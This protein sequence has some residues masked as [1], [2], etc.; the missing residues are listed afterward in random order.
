MAIGFKM[1]GITPFV[2]VPNGK[3]VLPVN[4]IDLLLRC[5]GIKGSTITTLSELLADT[6]T[7]QA[8]INSNN[9]IDYLVRSTEFA[10]SEALVPTMTSDTEPSGVASASSVYNSSYPAWKVFD[11][12]LNVS[13]S[14][15]SNGTTNQWVKYR[16]P[17]AQCVKSVS[18]YTNFTGGADS[19]IKNFRVEGSNDDS[20]F[21]TI[22]TGTYLNQSGNQSFSFSNNESY[23]YYRLYI[24]DRYSASTTNIQFVELQYYDSA[25]GF[26]ENSTAMTYIGAN[27]YASDTLLDDSTWLNA[28]CNSTYFESVLNVKVPTM[29]SNTTPSGEVITSSNIS[30]FD[31][32]KAFDENT[33]SSW[34]VNSASLNGSYIIYH[35]TSQVRVNKV[36]NNYR[37]DRGSVVKYTVWELYGSNDNVSYTD[38]GEINAN[39]DGVNTTNILANSNKYSYY[40]LV[41]KSASASGT[42]YGFAILQFYGRQDV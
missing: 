37:T 21:T 7:L 28:I 24:I 42:N 20:E 35:F 33:S 22:Y 36:V 14:W 23:L 19:T 12:D 13:S 2:S 17:T 3:T 10:K 15:V 39:G 38:I 4:D 30:G 18:I 6:T 8:V 31:G 27:N 1:G 41:C 9:A 5:A 25:E 11:K 40:K 29:T 16:F 34:R 26:T 32:Y